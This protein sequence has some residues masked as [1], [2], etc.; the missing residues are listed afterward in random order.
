M[1]QEELDY[2]TTT[3]AYWEKAWREL[4]TRIQAQ[5]ESGSYDDLYELECVINVILKKITEL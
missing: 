3:K 1:T 4:I 5:I 2:I